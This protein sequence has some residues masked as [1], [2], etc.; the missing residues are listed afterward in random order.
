MAAD[1]LI[2]LKMLLATIDVVPPFQ[3]PTLI[4]Y[5]LYEAGWCRPCRRAIFIDYYKLKIIKVLSC[6]DELENLQHLTTPR[7]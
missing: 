7:L 1:P 4:V 6:I 5:G 2:L 3:L